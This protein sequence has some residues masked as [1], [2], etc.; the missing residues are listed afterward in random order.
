M[1]IEERIRGL[2]CEKAGLEK[3]GR[4]F[5]ASIAACEDRIQNEQST[6]SALRLAAAENRTDL[7]DTN[8]KLVNLAGEL[9]CG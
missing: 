9:L 2:T 8:D 1:N 3:K 4:E 7:R 5:A 6:L